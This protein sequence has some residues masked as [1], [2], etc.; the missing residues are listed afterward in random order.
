MASNTNAALEI[1]AASG[2]L[3]IFLPIANPAIATDPADVF[4]RLGVTVEF[5]KG[6]LKGA[7]QRS[8]SDETLAVMIVTETK[9]LFG[10]LEKIRKRSEE[11]V[12]GHEHANDESRGSG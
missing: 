8:G 4:E 12:I 6:V 10:E 1:E 11:R 9:K 5:G 3:P 2:A 7:N